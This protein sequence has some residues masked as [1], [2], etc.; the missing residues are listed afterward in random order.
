MD[1]NDPARKY[2][3]KPKGDYEPPRDWLEIYLRYSLFMG[4]VGFLAMFLFLGIGLPPHLPVALQ[5]NAMLAV[6]VALVMLVRG[7]REDPP[8]RPVANKTVSPE[9]QDP[10]RRFLPKPKAPRQKK[11]SKGNGLL[12]SLDDGAWAF[13]IVMIMLIIAAYVPV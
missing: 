6:L 12:S 13:I 1:P 7:P 9:F 5:F 10:A 11:R 3:P 4:G 2:L 8:P